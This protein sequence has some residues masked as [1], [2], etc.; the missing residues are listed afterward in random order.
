MLPAGAVAL[1]LATCDGLLR[2]VESEGAHRGYAL[3]SGGEAMSAWLDAELLSPLRGFQH[4]IMVIIHMTTRG[5][6][7]EPGSGG[8][9]PARRRPPRTTGPSLAAAWLCGCR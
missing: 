4:M 6:G 7:G 8:R 3:A 1:S 5:A 9:A 2:L